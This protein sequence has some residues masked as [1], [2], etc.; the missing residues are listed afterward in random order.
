MRNVATAPGVATV[1]FLL[2]YGLLATPVLWRKEVIPGLIVV[3][4]VLAVALAVLSAIDLNR[5]QL[6][7]AITL[8]LVGLG[9]SVSYGLGMMPLWWSAVSA[10]LGFAL[11]AGVAHIYHHVRGRVG[12]GLGDA[13]LLA[14][15]GAWLGAEAFP[16]VLLWATGA[17]GQVGVFKVG[18]ARRA[19]GTGQ[20]T[21][22]LGVVRP[23]EA[24]RQ[25]AR[26]LAQRPQGRRRHA[27]LDLN[28]KSVDIE[29]FSVFLPN[30]EFDLDHSMGTAADGIYD[31]T[32]VPGQ[33]V[34]LTWQAGSTHVLMK[35]TRGGDANLDRVVDF[36][37]LV[38]LAQ[39]YNTSGQ[40][41][42]TR[43]TS[44]TTKSST[45]TTW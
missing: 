37:D 33:A 11:L 41:T 8:P 21:L 20:R 10:G 25:P 35:L 18:S 27:G 12:L 28:G 4:L 42:W 6:P 2:L 22:A 7:D 26:Q 19:G 39:H 38:V 24:H 23:P 1:A 30:D 16:T 5:Y 17:A 36:N 44:T 14:A 32:A 3:S 9:L 13:K 40:P 34:G 45:S 29:A 43:A 31:S 15:S